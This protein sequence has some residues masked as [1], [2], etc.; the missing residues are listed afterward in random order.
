MA[1]GKNL[2][3]KVPLSWKNSFSQGV[4]I[5]HK[6]KNFDDCKKVILCDDCDN[7]LSI[8]KNRIFSQS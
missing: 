6:M 8:S 2:I 4:V 5:S 1:D 3:A 7:L